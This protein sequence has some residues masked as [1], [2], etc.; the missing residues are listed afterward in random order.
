MSCEY[1]ISWHIILVQQAIQYSSNKVPVQGV[2]N[3]QHPELCTSYLSSPMQY[4]VTHMLLVVFAF[5]LSCSNSW[6]TFATL[7]SLLL[8]GKRAL[9]STA[10]ERTPLPLYFRCQVKNRH[11]RKWAS[12]MP[13]FIQIYAPRCPY[14]REYEHPD[15]Q[16][17]GEYRDPV[18]KIGIPHGCLYSRKYGY[19]GPCHPYNFTMQT[20]ICKSEIAF[21]G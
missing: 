13:I 6:D 10:F 4:P 20:C 21:N 15:A 9:V 2:P 7:H 1:I 16:I 14:L 8:R 19:R 12:R 5:L 18:V 11:P 3:H 17:H